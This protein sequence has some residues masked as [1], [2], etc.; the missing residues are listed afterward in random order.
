[1]QHD[2][3]HVVETYASVRRQP[4]RS[5][6]VKLLGQVLLLAEGK[7]ELL[8]HAE[9]PWASATFSGTRHVVALTFPGP[10][11]VAVGEQF[12]AVLPDHEFDL[13]GEIVADAAITEV[14]HA[15]YPE[16]RLTV[17]I[18]LLLLEDI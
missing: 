17:E 13:P 12:I 14:E 9:R 11:A 16:S 10:A 5:N 18:E 15:H 8:R 2:Y 3:R 6:W 1:M 4:R 7:A